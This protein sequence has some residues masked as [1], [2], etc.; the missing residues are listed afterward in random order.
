MINSFCQARQV[1]VAAISIAA[2]MSACGSVADDRPTMTAVLESSS[3]ADWREPDPRFLLHMSIPGGLIII[4]LAP[5]F[6]PNVIENIRLLTGADFFSSAA[7]TRSQEN[8]VAQWGDPNAGT[9]DATSYGEAAASVEAEFFR[10]AAGLS[11]VEI[12]SRDAYADQVGFVNGFPAGRDDERAWLT[13]CY[14]MLGVG[15]DM[16]PDSGNGAELY[17]VTGHS[18]RH[19]DRNVVLVGRVLQGMELLTTLPRG[20]GPLGFYESKEEQVAIELL[21]FA[22]DLPEDQRVGLEV[23]RTDTETFQQLV[24]A[25]R[26]RAEDWFV[27]PTDNIELCN[28]PIPV[29]AAG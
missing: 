15:R 18:P 16:S 27:D 26:Y 1:A 7:I 29:R 9:D 10:D 2:L 23:L 4:E 3:D 25:R 11:F 22:S 21:R 24:E 12:D 19:L 6:A 13:H 8:Y 5:D 20:T 17:V 28:V 14:G